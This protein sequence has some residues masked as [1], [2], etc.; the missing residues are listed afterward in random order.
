MRSPFAG[1]NELRRLS[2]D[3]GI[4]AVWGKGILRLCDQITRAGFRTIDPQKRNESGLARLFIFLQA[5]AGKRDIA[6]NIQQVIGNLERQAQRLR[7]GDKRRG[8]GTC[9][10]RTGTGRP[11]DQRTGLARLQRP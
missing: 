3:I 7:I 2:Q 5:F 9:H 11:F 4:R 10:A 1:N 8:V 6:L